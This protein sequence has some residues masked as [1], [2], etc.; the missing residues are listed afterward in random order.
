MS[1]IGLLER[2]KGKQ[3]T[4]ASHRKERQEQN[5]YVPKTQKRRDARL[6]G[7]SSQS[8]MDYSQVVDL[9]QAH[10][11]AGY[12]EG[13]AGYDRMEEDAIFYQPGEEASQYYETEEVAQGEDDEAEDVEAEDDDGHVHAAAPEPEPGQRRRDEVAS[14]VP[15]VGPSFPGGPQTTTLL[16]DYAKH[17][18]IPLWV[19]DNNVSV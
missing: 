16:S 14:V 19:N 11:Y 2:R 5:L 18:V 17:V 13:F 6:V 10:E 1:N 7:G 15:I 12:T 9:T 4:T 8:Q 3:A